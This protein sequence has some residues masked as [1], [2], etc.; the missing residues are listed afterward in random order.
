MNPLR[1]GLGLIA[2]LLPIPATAMPQ[3]AA[4]SSTRLVKGDDPSKLEKELNE[5]AANG[6]RICRAAPERIHNAVAD[7]LLAGHGET[8]GA[9]VLMESIPSGGANYQYA[10]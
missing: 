3:Q 4:A 7:I 10:V 2:L 1:I 5:A 6:Y 9:V 8:S